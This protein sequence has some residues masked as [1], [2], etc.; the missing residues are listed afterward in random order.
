MESLIRDQLSAH[1]ETQSTA[2][3]VNGS[4]IG[5]SILESVFGGG[6]ILGS[7]LGDNNQE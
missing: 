1:V 2:G 7:M 6:S 4:V 3:S 5:G